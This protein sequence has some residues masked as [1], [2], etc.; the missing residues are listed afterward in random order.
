MILD[1]SLFNYLTTANLSFDFLL[2]VYNFLFKLFGFSQ[3]TD[4]L[5]GGIPM[6]KLI[7]IFNGSLYKLGSDAPNPLM[8]VKETY[9]PLFLDHPSV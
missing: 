6:A 8:Q 9:K 5:Q 4:Y 7:P 2:Y 3:N 1:F